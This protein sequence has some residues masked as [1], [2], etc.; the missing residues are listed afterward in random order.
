MGIQ[1]LKTLVLTIK[2]TLDD[3]LISLGTIVLDFNGLYLKP[4][5]E[6]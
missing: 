4:S 3:N 6:V 1:K 5:F 2:Q